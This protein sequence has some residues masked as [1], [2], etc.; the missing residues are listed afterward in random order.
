[1]NKESFKSV[2]ISVFF[3][4]LTALILLAAFAF[5]TYNKPD[6][7]P[8]SSS[9]GIVAL[10]IGGLLCGLISTIIS[11]KKTLLIPALSGGAYCLLQILSTLIWSKNET[12]LKKLIVKIL[13]IMALCLVPSYFL[14]NKSSKRK[15]KR[16]LSKR[17]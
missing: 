8:Y 2:V 10:L 16:K 5:F 9:L 11:K 13:L 17:K 3:S 7:A 12:D 1:M 15:R 14:V 4:E 6:P